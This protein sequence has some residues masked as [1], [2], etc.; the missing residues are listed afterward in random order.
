MRGVALR[1]RPNLTIT[2]HTESYI[3]SAE[4]GEIFRPIAEASLF[5]RDPR[6]K[7]HLGINPLLQPI[8]GGLFVGRVDRLGIVGQP[9]R[10]TPV[11]PSHSPRRAA[12]SREPTPSAPP[13]SH[14][15]VV[16]PNRDLKSKGEIIDKR[17]RWRITMRGGEIDSISRRVSPEVD[18]RQ[19]RRL[20]YVGQPSR[21]TQQALHVSL[22]R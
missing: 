8:G 11:A 7:Q 15:P 18:G 12:P 4:T 9:S 2:F 19:A 21:L 3:R 6:F 10:L 22:G 16:S 5:L 17:A 13:I 20:S 14:S 1:F